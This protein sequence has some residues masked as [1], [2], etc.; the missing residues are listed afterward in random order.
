MQLGY[1]FVY[2]WTPDMELRLRQSGIRLAAYLDWIFAD[3]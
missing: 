3:D 1:Q 2:D